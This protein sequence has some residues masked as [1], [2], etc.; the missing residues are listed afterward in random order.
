M[1][2]E[3]GINSKKVFFVFSDVFEH[4]CLDRFG[5]PVLCRVRSANFMQPSPGILTNDTAFSRITNGPLRSSDMVGCKAEIGGAMPD[6]WQSQNPFI[7]ARLN[8][9]FLFCDPAPYAGIPSLKGS[10]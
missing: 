7:T 2:A 1:A 3:N 9:I 5:I 4:K 6:S 10:H 8:R